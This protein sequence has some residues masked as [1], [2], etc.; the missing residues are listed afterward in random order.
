MKIREMGYRDY[1]F[2]NGEEKRLKA[3]CRS[4]EF[5]EHKSLLDSAISSCPCIAPD[6]YYS[7]VGG[8]SYDDLIKIKCIPLPKA[9]FYGYQRKC[10]SIFRNFLLFYGKWR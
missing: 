3:Y 7:I 2:D 6:L 4:S 8:V 1:G 10:L 9:D 5:S